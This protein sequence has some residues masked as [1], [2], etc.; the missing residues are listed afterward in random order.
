MEGSGAIRGWGRGWGVGSLD[1]VEEDEGD[2]DGS[3]SGSG[4]G[5]GGMRP[6]NDG[7]C[8]SLSS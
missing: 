1:G 7:V 8:V 3:G 6:Y 2:E 5:G 4:S